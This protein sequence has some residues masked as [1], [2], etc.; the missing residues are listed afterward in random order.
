MKRI[1]LLAMLMAGFM[2]PLFGN[3]ASPVQDGTLSGL[4]FTSSFVNIV[5]EEIRITPDADF[6]KCLF[7]VTYFIHADSN[8]VQ[9]PLLFIAENYESGIQILVDGKPVQLLEVRVRAIGNGDSAF[10]SFARIFEADEDGREEVLIKWDSS[11]GSTYR[12]EDLHYFETNFSAGPHKITVDYVSELWEDRSDWVLNSSFRYALS[13]A[14]HWKSFG[15]LHVELDQRKCK[16]KMET[17]LGPSKKGEQEGVLVWDFDQLPGEM[18]NVS[19]VAEVSDFAKT[20]MAID[21]E[22]F[23]WISAIIFFLLHLLL[24]WLHRKRKPEKKFSVLWLVGSILIPF[25]SILIY[26]ISK[27]WINSALGDAAAHRS[28]YAF[29]IIIFYPIGLIGYGLIAWLADFFLR[30]MYKGN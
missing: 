12:L 18:L 15:H 11:R 25:A 24:M 13:P 23:M 8:G 7:E 30:K 4:P 10:A 6:R 17:N 16:R 22:G 1:A 2:G 5:R 3:M 20:M 27:G 14:K 9:I 28:D 26:I 19:L 29:L 21:R